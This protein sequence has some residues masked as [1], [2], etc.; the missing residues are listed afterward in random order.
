MKAEEYLVRFLA[1]HHELEH[2]EKPLAAFL[3]QFTDRNRDATEDALDAFTAL[4]Q[5]TIDVA[6]VL[7]GDLAFAIFDSRSG[8]K[9]LSPF[10]AALFDAQMVALSRSSITPDKVDKV[11]RT[12]FL[13]DLGELFYVERFER[14]ISRATSDVDRVMTR[15]H[16]MQKLVSKHF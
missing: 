11:S 5:R 16:M 13:A 15:V 8:N 6:D 12:A 14:A 1:F 9:V 2:Y 10:N 4:F 3:N 7:F